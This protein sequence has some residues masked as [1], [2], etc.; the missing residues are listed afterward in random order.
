[1]DVIPR[2]PGPWITS[3]FVD[4]H[5]IEKFTAIREEDLSALGALL[6]DA[7]EGGASVSFLA[8]LAIDD[9]IAFWRRQTPAPARG[10]IFVARG[11]DGI[12]GAVMLAPAWPPNQPHR[13]DVAKLLVHR[14]AR[15]RGVGSALMR[16]LETHAAEQGFTLL[17]LDTE[18][19]GPGEKVYRAL[20]WIECGAIPEYAIFADGSFCETVLFYKK[21]SPTS[22]R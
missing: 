5:A 20:G 4:A 21:L 8:P 11:D 7:I 15:R 3:V 6:V 9:A 16:A 18:R 1:M 14:R 22:A 19:G 10:A 2:K 13:A 12:D 17:V